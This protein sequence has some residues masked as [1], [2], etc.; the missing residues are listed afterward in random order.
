MLEF[1]PRYLFWGEK[2]VRLRLKAAHIGFAVGDLEQIAVVDPSPG[3]DFIAPCNESVAVEYNTGEI[4]CTIPT[5]DM[6]RQD[7][8]EAYVR[9]SAGGQY[10]L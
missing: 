6:L 2:G 10:S 1:L 5:T 9:I 4:E 3:N 7:P 8:E